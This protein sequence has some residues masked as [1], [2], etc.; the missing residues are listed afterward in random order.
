MAPV[1]MQA[2]HTTLLAYHNFFTAY[3]KHRMITHTR[4]RARIAF[5]R[6]V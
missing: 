4:G 5:M 6:G 2:V 1:Y 3:D